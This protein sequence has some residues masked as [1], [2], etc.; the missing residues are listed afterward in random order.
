MGPCVANHADGRLFAL[1][2]P[3][4]SRIPTTLAQVWW[5]LAWPGP[6]AAIAAPRLH[7]GGAAAGGPLLWHEPAALD[8]MQ[9]LTAEHL[10]SLG[11]ED[12]QLKEFPRQIC[13]SGASNWP[14][15]WP[16]VS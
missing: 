6:A 8:P 1:G 16:M 14:L 7:V 12:D 10:E 13:V 11:F 9:P 3:G 4:A 5:L 15:G 2:S